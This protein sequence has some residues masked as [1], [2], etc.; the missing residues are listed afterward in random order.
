MAFYYL[1]K[2]LTV[3]KS[4][5]ARKV[6][7]LFRYKIGIPDVTQIDWKTVT[8]KV[9]SQAPSIVT[10]MI[11]RTFPTL[12][13]NEILGVQPM[14]APV[15][16]TFYMD[17][18]YTKSVNRNGRRWPVWRR[19]AGRHRN[20]IPTHKFKQ[21]EYII[22]RTKHFHDIIAELVMHELR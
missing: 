9:K 10:P 20:T 6:K 14:S 19:N 17:Y 13:T 11:R 2:D 1:T 15:G 3:Y 21:H 12:I 5:G 7:R 8:G 4:A 22:L 18:K 16:Q